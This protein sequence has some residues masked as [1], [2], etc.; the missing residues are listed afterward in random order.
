MAKVGSGRC[1]PVLLLALLA[2]E[3][4]AVADNRSESGLH[5]SRPAM[6]KIPV[7]IIDKL[8]VRKREFFFDKCRKL[9]KNRLCPMTY[10]D[11]ELIRQFG[12]RNSKT[13]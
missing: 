8:E 9:I 2:S 3:N 4:V 5:I 10:K 11:D 7:L 6:T 1:V 13:A 12:I